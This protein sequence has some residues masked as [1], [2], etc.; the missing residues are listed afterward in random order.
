M[1]L[2][3]S[4]SDVESLVTMK[5]AIRAVETAFLEQHEGK[6]ACP[7]RLIISVDKH[8]GFAYC[9]PAYLSRAESLAIKI[10]TQFKGNLKHGL[11]TI[12]ASILLNDPENGRLLA[13]MDGTYLTATRT[14]A[15]SAVATKYLA[16]KGSR[17][18]GV[19]G[20]GGQARA[21][22]RGLR[23][24]LKNLTRMKVYDILPKRAGEFA[25]SI[26]REL[27]ITVEA[28][29]TSRQCVENSDVIVLATTSLV[30]VL[31]GDWIKAGAHINSIGVVGPEGRELDDKTIKKA[32]IVV[33][34]IEGALAETGDLIIPIKN[35]II[36]QDNIY[37]ELYEIVSAEKPG[38]TSQ[39]ETTC[40]KA[41][42][43]A[44]EDAA[45]AKMVYDKAKEKG[46]GKEIE[47]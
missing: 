45:V 35:G 43:L 39:I 1:V 19:L 2:F 3:L 25:E 33:D 28:V 22:V 13:L 14:G 26:S 4:R 12:L 8:E 37:A 5:E 24:V 21:Q 32:K 29:E 41:V 38:R 7:K 46:I 10:V 27:S 30:P 20:T 18:I 15:A 11:P 16:R 40:W 23:E 44:L 9:M 34:T 47:I 6:A 31:D 36:S 17:V 42:G